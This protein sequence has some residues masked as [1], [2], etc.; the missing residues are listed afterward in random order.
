MKTWGGLDGEKEASDSLD[1]GSR[2]LSTSGKS[3]MAESL[4]ALGVTFPDSLGNPREHPWPTCYQTL[5][6]DKST[7]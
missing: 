5:T 4:M 7:Y 3:W 6:G 1:L 2:A